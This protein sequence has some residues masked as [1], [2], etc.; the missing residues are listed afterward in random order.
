M[1]TIIPGQI[2]SD[3][4]LKWLELF[5]KTS[6]PCYPIDV[7]PHHEIEERLKRVKK[8]PLKKDARVALAELELNE[9]QV[10]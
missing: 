1:R 5:Y 3:Q 2:H 7:G 10:K 8:R 9:H 6:P 4:T